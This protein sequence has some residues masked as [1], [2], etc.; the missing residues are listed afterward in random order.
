MSTNDTRSNE[1]SGTE[2]KQRTLDGT[3]FTVTT[4]TQP[5]TRT[6]PFCGE[7]RIVDLGNHLRRHPESGGCDDA[8]TGV[9]DAQRR[10]EE[11]DDRLGIT[12]RGP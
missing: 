7:P 5:Q 4:R 6:C 8:G 10:I 12:R 9:D 2:Q 11:F 3:S 1:S